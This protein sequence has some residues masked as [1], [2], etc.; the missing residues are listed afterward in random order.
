MPGRKVDEV[1]T[2]SKTRAARPRLLPDAR[3]LP[4]AFWWLFGATLVDRLGGFAQIYLALYLTGVAGV[5]LGTAGLIASAQAVGSLV[6]TPL[7]GALADRLGRRPMLIAGFAATGLSWLHVASAR[8]EVH[9][10]VAVFLA[11]LAGS[12]GRPAMAAAVADVVPEP[13][14]RRAYALNYWAI[15]LGFAFSASVAGLLADVSP[16]LVFGLDAATSF[17]VALA[18]WR[19]LPDLAPAPAI[20]RAATTP[21][22]TPAVDAGPPES[23][24]SMLREPLRD[25]R[26]LAFLCMGL[27]NA[28]IYMQSGIALAADLRHDGLGN[29]YGPLVAINGVLIVLAQPAVVRATDGV[30]LVRVLAVGNLLVGLGF[31]ATGFCDTLVPHGLAIAAWTVGEI[32]SASSTPV[33][34]T[35]MAPPH[36]RATYQGLFHASWSAAAF[37]P[38]AGG[39][40][41]DA[42]GPLALWTGCLAL[43][44]LCAL[45]TLPLRGLSDRR[46][47]A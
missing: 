29:H 16:M 4:R 44:A 17:T 41:L 19:A 11:G 22:P 37:A 1:P 8:G 31:F 38:A 46:E 23:L 42:W 28:A 43:G 45:L 34:L 20:A 32:L 13:D 12:L 18:L 6:G 35:R 9:L 39:Y 2:M 7:A 30:D 21:A 14:R 40:V 26:F 3:G 10:G 15:N 27:V 47:T 33:L 25:L 24:L 36:R 5:S